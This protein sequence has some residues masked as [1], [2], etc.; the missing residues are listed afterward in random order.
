MPI[1]EQANSQYFDELDQNERYQILFELCLNTYER[2]H[3][4]TQQLKREIFVVGLLACIPL[5]IVTLFLH[6]NYTLSTW[7]VS[8]G[9]LGGF[10]GFRIQAAILERR[11]NWERGKVIKELSLQ[12]GF[13][14][15]AQAIDEGRYYGR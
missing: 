1:E 3:T 8:I 12:H 6:V 10:V 9:L 13:P 15:I 14:D 4:T 2:L 11:S 5:V 7:I